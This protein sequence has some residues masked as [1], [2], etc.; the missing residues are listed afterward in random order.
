MGQL[1]RKWE[2]LSHFCFLP[3]EV[4]DAP[5]PQ[6]WGTFLGNLQMVLGFGQ[7]YQRVLWNLEIQGSD[8][9]E[10]QC[11]HQVCLGVQPLQPM[12]KSDIKEDSKITNRT[13][14]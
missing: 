8:L 3:A 9:G 6:R 10:Y 2:H 12:I 1:L 13:R 5:D 7:W 11:I 4:E 14:L